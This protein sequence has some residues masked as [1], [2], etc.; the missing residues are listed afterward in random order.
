MRRLT[1]Q[2]IIYVCMTPATPTSFIT[3]VRTRWN[4]QHEMSGVPHHVHSRDARLGGAQ[5]R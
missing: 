5:R 1:D 2:N 3:S 4:G